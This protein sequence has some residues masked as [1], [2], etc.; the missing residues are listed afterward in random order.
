[1]WKLQASLGFAGET[2]HDGEELVPWTEGGR[3]AISARIWAL[4]RAF[5]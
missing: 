1:M 5:L 4:E 2:G 3:A